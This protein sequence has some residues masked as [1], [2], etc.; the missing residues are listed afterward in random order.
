MHTN[1]SGPGS[2]AFVACAL[3]TILAGCSGSNNGIPAASSAAIPSGL[4]PISGERITITEFSDLPKSPYFFPLALT[5]APDGA[6]WVADDIDQDAGASTIDRIA[7]SGKRTRTFSYQ[8]YASPAF[9]DLAFGPD[10]AL[11]IT[12]WGDSQIVRMTKQGVFSTFSLGGNGPEGIVSGPDH[13]LWFVEN[14]FGGAAV[15]RITTKG[16]ITTFTNGISAGTSAQ[17]ITVGPDGNLWF[18]ES[19]GDRIGRITTRGRV[20]EFSAG[21]TPN[22]QPYSIAL[23]PDGALWF[24]EANAGRIGR[25]TTSGQVTE[26]SRGITLT[27]KPF[28]IAAGP[29]GAM[30]FTEFESTGSSYISNSK[31]GRITMTGA[32]KEYPTRDSKSEPEGIAAGSDGN[33][34]FVET[35][36]N[37]LGRVNL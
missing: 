19:F 33:M 4:G 30:W 5:T 1:I 9:V 34:W 28:D 25:I 10:G 35:K 37:R 22:S 20:T 27:E 16:R 8:N 11:W 2:S 13:A 21:I 12:D 7:S 17:D 36:I 29:D 6:L 3:A 32:I 14:I 24:T 31:I 23:G 26:Y 18:T 15:G